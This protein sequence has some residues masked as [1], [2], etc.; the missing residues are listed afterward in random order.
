[1]AKLS[2]KAATR[3]H[4][5]PLC[6]EDAEGTSEENFSFCRAQADGWGPLRQFFLSH[7]CCVK[8]FVVTHFIKRELKT[9]EE[10]KSSGEGRTPDLLFP[11]FLLP[12]HSP[13]SDGPRGHMN[14]DSV[15]VTWLRRTPGETQSAS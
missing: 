9:Q 8:V 7:T 4:A 12:S 15:T 10:Y 5:F 2:G 13:R 1:M 14:L 3:E 6:G 11:S